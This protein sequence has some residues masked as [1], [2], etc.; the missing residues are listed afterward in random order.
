MNYINHFDESIKEYIETL[1]ASFDQPILVINKD[2]FIIDCNAI[3]SSLYDLNKK[4][5]VGSHY[6]KLCSKKAIDLPAKSLLELL[7]KNENAKT[8]HV[9]NEL[10]IVKIYQWTT[11]TLPL[12]NNSEVYCLLGHDITSFLDLA[13]KEQ[14]L[15]NL[16]I[17][18]IPAQIFWKDKNL[19]YLGC[20]SAFVKSLG[21][22]SKKQIIGK[23]DFDLP[24]DANDSSL[25]RIDD[26]YVMQSRQPKLDIEERQTLANGGERILSTCKVPLINDKS[27]VYGVLGV[28]R[29][30]TEQKQTEE[31][32]KIAKQDAEK[33]SFVKSEFIANM[34]HDIRTPL[35]G[36]V[37]MSQL[38][39]DAINDPEQKQYAYWI[40]KCGIQ[41]LRLLNDILSVISVEKAL[42]LEVH[43][44]VFSLRECIND[45]IQLE[46]PST[47]MKEI[48][49]NVYIDQDIPDQLIT[50]RAKLYRIL[51]N[52]LG[53]AIKFTSVGAVSI[54]V[55]KRNITSEQ[56]ILDFRVIDTGIGIPDVFQDKIFDRFY[57]INPS[58]K[59]IYSGYGIGL[60]IAKS[61]VQLLGGE[62]KLISQ[63]DVGTTFYFDLIC[64]FAKNQTTT[65]LSEPPSLHVLKPKCNSKLTSQ[66]LILLVEDNYVA[67]KILENMAKLAKLNFISSSDGE[68]ALEIAI[69]QPIHLIIT[70]IGLPGISGNELTREVR[71]WER[72]HG[73]Y[74]VPI[75]GLTAHA[76][77]QLKEECLRAGMN[78][79]Y[80]K[81]IDLTT[82]Q[83]VADKYI[84][85]DVI[86]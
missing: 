43:S 9:H 19:V 4:D 25:F 66:P 52:L 68:S 72:S 60:H 62:L 81:P 46:R 65:H 54:E 22:E 14:S 21:L 74:G 11:F 36:V 3:V 75:I 83:M 16:M 8:T 76:D 67:L 23:T 12:T 86:T 84:G 53:N 38:L 29:D 18:Y 78:D 6:F 59:G 85:G 41:L 28:Y 32:L 50:D 73:R 26:L 64:N 71:L 31:A 35:S 79:I 55:K 34:S 61:Y 7:D 48:E 57:R 15:S 20:N 42:E 47:E 58:Y 10:Q 13:T 30:I 39:A 27:E 69:T 33:A 40:H 37:G 80:T 51:L 2:S 77:A 49:L 70:D 82:L 56:V 63:Q 1:V 45:I 5:I 44:D 24:V 17:D